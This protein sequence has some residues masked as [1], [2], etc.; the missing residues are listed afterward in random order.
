MAEKEKIKIKNLGW[1]IY[2]C[3]YVAFGIYCWISPVFWSLIV[4]DYESLKSFVTANQRV[5]LSV[6]KLDPQFIEIKSWVEELKSF[7][8][9]EFIPLSSLHLLWGIWHNSTWCLLSEQ[10]SVWA[11]S[12]SFQHP[13][14]ETSVW[15]SK[16]INNKVHTIMILPQEL[17]F[18]TGIMFDWD[19][20]EIF[21]N[22]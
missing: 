8:L 11:V 20:D 12:S 6:I 16:Q 15:L 4:I 17:N 2:V 7:C 3:I 5:L 18:S 19:N 1:G 13:T 14:W 22:F 10:C 21:W 9:P